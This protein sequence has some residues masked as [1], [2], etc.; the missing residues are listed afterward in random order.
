MTEA[1]EAMTLKTLE[2]AVRRANDNNSEVLRCEYNCARVHFAQAS[3]FLQNEGARLLT[4]SAIGFEAGEVMLTYT[5]EIE[6]T[7][8][9]ILR[10]PTQDRT[11]DSLFSSF[12]AADFLEREVNNLFG[13]KFLGHPNLAQPT[14]LRQESE[15]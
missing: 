9:I 8:S 10:T 4:L 6:T 2:E 13:V 1:G 14:A 15:E 11:A 3:R 5:F 7:G 12:P